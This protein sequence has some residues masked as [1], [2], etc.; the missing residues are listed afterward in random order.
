MTRATVAE[1]D[2]ESKLAKDKDRVEQKYPLTEHL[3]ELRKRVVYIF[4]GLAVVFIGTYSQGRVLMNYLLE[5]LV[6]YMPENSTVSFL[7]ITEGFVTELKLAAIAAVF[8]AMPYILYQLWKFIAPGL[9]AQERKY[10]FGFVFSASVLFFTG[11]SFAYFIVF[12]FGFQFFLKYAGPEWNMVANLSVSWYLTFVTR[13]IMAFGLV[14]EMPVIVFFLVK[15]GVV[16][17]QMLVKHRRYAIVGIFVAA[18]VLTPPDVISQTAMAVPLL[19]LY[20]ISIYI[21]RV[22]GRKR[23]LENT[24]VAIYD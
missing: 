15:M 19:V 18:A 22:F 13:L 5:P 7:K 3:I 24:D 20:Q 10:V 23:E 12:P 4:A 9:Y 1:L 17:E 6:R 8:V 14:F 2:I 21:A 11:A 16:N